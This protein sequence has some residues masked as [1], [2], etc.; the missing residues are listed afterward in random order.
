MRSI[1]SEQL[2]KW[3]GRHLQGPPKALAHSISTPD[4]PKAGSLMFLKAGVKIKT[5]GEIAILVLETGHNFAELAIPPHISVFETGQFRQT[6]SQVLAI[7]DTKSE[8][9]PEGTAGSASLSSSAQLGSAVRVGDG[10]V[11]GDGAII[12]SNVWIGAGAVIEA[13]AHVGTGTRIHSNA[14][15][16]HHC[17][18]GENCEIQSN[19][20]VGSDGFGFIPQKS[21][22]PVKIP[23][24]GRVILE[25]FVEIGANCA[26]D[27]GA[28]GD[29]VIGAGTKIDN[30]CHI[31]HN[32]RIGKN[33]LI[34]AGFFMAGSSRIGDRFSCGGN[35][36]VSD[37]IT[38]TDDVVLGGRAT[39][40]SDITKPGAYAG[41]P[42]EPM[43]EALKTL[44]NLRELTRLR[45]DVAAL[46]RHLKLD[47]P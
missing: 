32:C 24:I 3:G 31:A 41:F 38:I 36:V 18:V 25:D 40:T 1:S 20:T 5:W 17:L 14:V 6:M 26:I 39:V 34:T 23:Q 27:R 19:T 42:L 4:E 10:V 9:F 15:I 33:C 37:H 28:I 35:A 46:R 21:T 45:K 43:K 7:F 8:A 13:H 16:G 30:L 2:E 29:T 11:I 22:H 47:P 12:G 44:A